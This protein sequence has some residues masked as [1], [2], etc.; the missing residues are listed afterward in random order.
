MEV[1][2]TYVFSLLVVIGLLY[3]WLNKNQHYFRDKPIPSL[4][5][6]PLIG[7]TGPLLFKRVSLP[8][9]IKPLYDKCAG[10]KILGFFDTNIPMYMLRDPELIKQIGVKDFDH[11]TDHR[12][13]FGK[14]HAEDSDALFPKTLFS[15][16]DH[17]W[18]SMRATISPA[19]TGSKMRQ[20]FDLVLECCESMV[21][22]YQN[23]IGT[24]MGREYEMKDVFSRFTNDVIATS[25]FGLR[26]DSS[27]NR[28]NE[29]YAQGK[30]M[31]RFNRLSVALRI[32][33]CRLMPTVV[34]PFGLDIIDQEQRNYFSSLIRDAVKQRETQG[35]VRPDMINLLMQARKGLLQH[36]KESEQ[37]EGFAT[38]EE[39]EV[40]KAR[41]SKQMTEIE[42]I[43]QCFIFFLA[44]FD[45][46]STC[47]TFLMYELT[48]NRAVQDKLYGE[49][50]ETHQSLNGKSLSYDA[51]Q[52][53][54]YMDMVV[55]EALRMWPP[56]AAIDRLCVRDYEL[57]DADGLRFTIKNG[58][59]IWLPIYG[60]HHDPKYY[61][62]PEKFIPE[63]FS[64]EN[65]SNVNLGAYLPFGIGP[66]NC[67][68]SRFALMEVKAIVYY[69]LKN[70]TFERT[71]NTEVPLSLKK[72]SGTIADKGVF[73]EFRPRLPSAS[74][75]LNVD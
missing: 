7:N 46:V 40:G 25:A 53:M 22:F 36:Q 5:F 11:F 37:N 73:V 9:F 70:F 28:D 1:E 62:S 34:R 69:M 30:K 49:I 43:A 3:R 17:K 16:T 56:I 26:V 74:G 32:V 23:E 61:P 20:M 48:V 18:R 64:D 54:K 72:G 50:M 14:N 8:E 63:R 29:F 45:T 35:I 39:S 38:V 47:L 58:A 21:Q 31:M 57:V 4:P 66:R 59:G 2:L 65:K 71:A 55:S 41:I 6:K 10:S 67:I 24:Q 27:K 44:G 33:A 60:L 68:G 19:F 42:M 52:K 51:V 15:L 13:V 12:P 75:V